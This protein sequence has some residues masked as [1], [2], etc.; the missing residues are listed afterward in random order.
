MY[1][2]LHKRFK[3]CEWPH[4]ACH[5]TVNTSIDVP[6]SVCSI[7]DH[8][9]I[10]VQVYSLL[11]LVA[12]QNQGVDKDEQNWF[13]VSFWLYLY[14]ISLFLFFPVML[15]LTTDIDPMP[16]DAHSWQFPLFRSPLG[17]TLTLLSVEQHLWLVLLMPLDETSLHSRCRF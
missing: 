15:L 4:L 3:R 14:E 12:Y 6:C 1:C 5:L 11:Q 16:G 13:I 7:C 2:S 17:T 10:F 8:H 9:L